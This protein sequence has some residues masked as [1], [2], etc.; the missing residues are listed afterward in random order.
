MIVTPEGVA[1]KDLA[2]IR[3][4]CLFILRKFNLMRY[5]EKIKY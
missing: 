1:D 5:W 3:F 2:I 4:Q